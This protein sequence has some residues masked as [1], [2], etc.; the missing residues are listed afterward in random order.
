MKRILTIIIA[1]LA[2][3]G[4][5]GVDLGMLGETGVKVAETLT[6][7]NTSTAKGVTAGMSSSDAAN[8]IINRDYYSTLRAIHGGSKEPA[9]PLL[10]IIANDGQPIKIDAKVLRVNAPRT[11]GSASVPISPP[12]EIESTG[13]KVSREARAWILGLM[14]WDIEKDREKTR[15]LVVETDAATQRFETAEQNQ[16][17]RDVAGTRND[18]AA[19]DRAEADKIRA[20]ADRIRAAATPAATP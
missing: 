3:T 7:E 19:L 2:L 20:E 8:V 16:L 6:D 1:A 13:F 18:P 15:R 5:A 14:G 10:E 12:L 11:S 17:I 9:P 4:C